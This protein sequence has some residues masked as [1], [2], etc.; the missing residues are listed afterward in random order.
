MLLLIFVRT[1]RFMCFQIGVAIML[2]YNTL[3]ATASAISN[4]SEFVMSI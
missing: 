3:K 1:L 2:A 4:A